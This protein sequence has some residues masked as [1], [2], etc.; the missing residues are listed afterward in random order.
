LTPDGLIPLSDAEAAR[1]FARRTLL[2]MV[3][4]H[5]A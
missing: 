5:T 4:G 1:A 3:G 2:P